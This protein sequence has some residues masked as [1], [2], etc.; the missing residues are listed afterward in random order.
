MRR[1]QSPQYCDERRA[2]FALLFTV[3]GWTYFQWKTSPKQLDISA[4]QFCY[5]GECSLSVSVVMPCAV[6]G[7]DSNIRVCSLHFSQDD[8]E[9]P[10]SIVKSIGVS[11]RVFLKRG[12]TPS[13]NLPGSSESRK[14]QRLDAGDVPLAAD[15]TIGART[16]EPVVGQPGLTD[17]GQTV[18]R[19]DVAHPTVPVAER[20]VPL[21]TLTD[22]TDT[23]S[24]SQITGSNDSNCSAANETGYDSYTDEG[25]DIPHDPQPSQKSVGTQAQGP[26]KVTRGVQTCRQKGHSKGS[27]ASLDARPMK[28]VGVQADLMCNSSANEKRARSLSPIRLRSST[29]LTGDTAPAMDSITSE[30]DLSMAQCP[31]DPSYTPTLDSTVLSTMLD[32]SPHED[33]KYIVFE[34]ELRKLFQTCPTCLQ[35]CEAAFTSKGTLLRVTYSCKDGH[36]RIWE[37]QP[38]I[39]NKP[40]GNVL[41]SAAMLFSG[42][43]PIPTLRMLDLMNIKVFCEQTYFNY[44]RGYLLPAIEQVSQLAKPE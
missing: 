3:F 13:Q 27:Q 29:P 7:C 19:T 40:A 36:E 12:V 42:S 1:P 35:R 20:E 4:T 39:G 18:C 10:P 21:A 24:Q 30:E 41:L 11:F 16:I 34:S 17:H 14:R 31:D 44:Q 9:S 32:P 25:T 28:S 22:S 6:P 5:A 33:N 38:Y 2:P 15:E 43:N 23:I 37:S 26:V 8:Y